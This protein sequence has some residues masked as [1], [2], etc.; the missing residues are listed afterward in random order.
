M[1]TPISAV[2]VVNKQTLANGAIA[3]TLRVNG[4]A[5]SDWTA[6]F[7]VTAATAATDVQSWLQEQKT[8]AAAQY[9]AMQAAHATLSSL[10]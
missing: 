5:S 7:Y 1:S 6:T 2:A 10:T 9:D 3:V 4:D 8:S